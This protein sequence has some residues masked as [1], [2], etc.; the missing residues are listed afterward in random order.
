MADADEKPDWEEDSE[1]SEPEPSAAELEVVDEPDE[2][3]SGLRCELHD[4]LRVTVGTRAVDD[5]LH[6]TRLLR[7]RPGQRRR[8][9]RV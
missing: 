9:P 5:G 6:G 7:S 8:M 3:Q 2:L 4:D 1:A